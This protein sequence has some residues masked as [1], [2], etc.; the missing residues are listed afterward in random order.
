M[1]EY[2][3]ASLAVQHA[4]LAVEEAALTATY[5]QT[6]VSAVTSALTLAVSSGL[7]LYGFRLM[8][9]GTEQRRA[10]M[11]VA[12]AAAEQRHA[13]SMVALTELIRRTGS[14]R[15]DGKNPERT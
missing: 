2:E 13:E 1:T 5:W 9:Q 15:P 6:G 10:E 8:R 14:S 11:D 12:A 4:S 7:V 3:T